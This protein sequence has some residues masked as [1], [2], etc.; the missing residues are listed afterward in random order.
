MRGIAV[1]AHFGP[2]IAHQNPG[3]ESGVMNRFALPIAGLLSILA[4]CN[5]SSEPTATN[6]TANHASAGGTP[7]QAVYDFLEAVRTGNDQKAADMLSPLARQ[8]TAE[9]QMV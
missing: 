3:K 7:D 5:Q 8:K 4:G 1:G 9:K 6:R 2:Q